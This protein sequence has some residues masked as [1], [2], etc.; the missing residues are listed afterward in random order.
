MILAGPALGL[1]GESFDAMW[2]GYKLWVPPYLGSVYVVWSA[3]EGL[4]VC[5]LVS[6]GGRVDSVA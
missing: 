1:L 2:R 4:Y 6:K 5:S 3:R